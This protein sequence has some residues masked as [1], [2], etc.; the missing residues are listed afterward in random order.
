MKQILQMFII[1]LI[2]LLGF[3]EMGHTQV[4]IN[5][6]NSLPDTSALLD[7][8]STSKGVLPPRMTTAQR[9]AIASPA[10][11]LVIYNADVKGLNLFNGKAWTTLSGKFECGLSQVFDIDS[12]R[13]NTLLIGQ[14]CW[15]ASNLNTGT[16]LNLGTASTNNGTIEKYCYDDL[17]ANCD[18]Y[19]G[20]YQWNEAMQYMLTEGV[21]GIC[22]DGW[23]LPT[24]AEFETLYNFLGGSEIAGAALKEQ[25]TDH[26]CYLNTSAT[27]SSG[28]TGLG[29]GRILFNP[30]E[31]SDKSA[32]A[33]FWTSTYW[34]EEPSSSFLT[35][36]CDDSS[37]ALYGIDLIPPS[38]FSVRC[39][40]VDP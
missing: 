34:D 27:N 35:L 2:F 29:A 17:T 3:N 14:Q 1:M 22:P 15:L 10:E 23:H 39:V 16:R 36:R 19:G 32:L 13:Y 33:F 25:G 40:R 6:D 21:Q 30:Q 11:G 20:L 9:D 4:G 12:N 8:K 7:V 5:D 28:F 38:S 31:Y 24:S 18:V 26:W 37:A